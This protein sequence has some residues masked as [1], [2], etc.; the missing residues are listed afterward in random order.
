MLK[1]RNICFTFSCFRVLFDRIQR[2]LLEKLRYHAGSFALLEFAI[3]AVNNAVGKADVGHDDFVGLKAVGD[4]QEEFGCRHY[5]VGTVF[6]QSEAL[7]ALLDGQ[8]GELAVDVVQLPHLE[9][10]FTVF[11]LTQFEQLVDVA[12]RTDDARVGK[13]A[14]IALQHGLHLQPLFLL[15]IAAEH[16]QGA[17]VER[18]AF[19]Q[20]SVV[21]ERYL[22]AAAAHVDIG[23]VAH[24]SFI[25]TLR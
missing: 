7:H 14:H 25:Q 3:E 17:D 2:S 1:V 13:L 4:G 11:L 8:L 23:E 9:H 24:P 15:D 22:G 20:D 18:M 6:L 5:D 21:E 12:A 16:A 10:F 19:R